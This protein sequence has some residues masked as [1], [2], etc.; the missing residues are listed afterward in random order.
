MNPA[1]WFATGPWESPE[2]LICSILIL[3]LSALLQATIGFAAGVLGIP[4]L[5]WA[6]NSLPES[7]ILI[8]TAML[9]QNL[10]GL[11]RLRKNLT[12]QDVAVPA[13]IRVAFLPIGILGLSTIIAS[14]PHLIDQIVGVLIL[15][16]VVTQWVSGE[17]WKSAGRW[18]WVLPTFGVSGVLQGL[19]GMSAPP[20]VLW[21]QGQ[22]V[23]TDKRREPFC[24]RCI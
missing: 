21:L 22:R 1:D 9:P 4:L 15:F 2:R 16:A 11:W 19:S 20:M 8:I 14:A 17:N 6:G 3:A 13:S 10:M 7:Q 23:P 12:V 24:F 5:L 18:Y